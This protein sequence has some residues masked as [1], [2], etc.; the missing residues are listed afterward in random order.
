MQRTQAKTAIASLWS[1]NDGS[2]QS[3]MNAF[4]SLLQKPNITKAE[5]LREA[6]I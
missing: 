2:T 4:Y 3:L 5:V 6:Q 1:V